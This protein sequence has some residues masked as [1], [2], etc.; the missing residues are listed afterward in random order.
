MFYKVKSVKPLENFILL[1]DF[2]NGIQK[3]YDVKKLFDKFTYF[4]NLLNINGLFEQVKV[5]ANGYAVSWNDDLDIACNEL[6]NNGFTN[7]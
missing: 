1:I 3:Y 2:E 7:T 6:W 4:Q 5:E